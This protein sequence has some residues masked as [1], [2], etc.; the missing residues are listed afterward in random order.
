MTSRNVSRKVSTTMP[1]TIKDIARH[2]GVSVST[3]SYALNGGPRPVRNDVR[4]KVLAA[5]SALDYRPN[6]LA[7]TLI[8]GRSFTI[9][10]VPTELTTNLTKSPY[11]TG[12]LDGIVNA[13]EVL[14]QDVLL[15]TR[16]D[17]TSPVAFV[18]ALLDGRADGLLFLAPSVDSPA[19]EQLSDKIPIVIA[20][21]TD[22]PGLPSF[23]CDNRHGVYQAIDYLVSL[24]HRRIG[25]LHG[26][27][28]LVDGIE[29]L[30]AFRDAMI[31]F[32]AD[33]RNEWIACGDFTPMGGFEAGRRMLER[34]PRPTAIF[35][36]NDEMAAGLLQAAYSLGLSVPEDISVIGFDDVPTASLLHPS[37]TTV[38]QPL[39]ELGA[40]A[41][42]ALIAQINGDD[43]V[44][45]I[46]FKTELI[47]RKSTTS[48]KEDPSS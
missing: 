31:E 4:D 25:N 10:V 29:R 47:V 16:F 33:L 40:A 2:L 8:T 27:M 43:A 17:Q 21:G 30:N 35:C 28:H 14:G 42:H 9:G 15:Y 20:S 22:V 48:P 23:T 38:R 45:H 1:V 44:P 37:L 32:D 7:R 3:V 36:A 34:T 39:E 12:C 13:A 19:L 11:F 26:K 5:A 41:L 6:H 18:N 46:Q 24:G